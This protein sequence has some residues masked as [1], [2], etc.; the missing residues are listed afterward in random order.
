MDVPVPSSG[1]LA[2]GLGLLLPP[3]PLARDLRGV[4]CV[5]VSDLPS[6]P[7]ASHQPPFQCLLRHL[8]VGL[9][10]ILPIPVT[11]LPMCMSV[12]TYVHVYVHVYI[13]YIYPCLPCIYFVNA[14]L[15]Y[16]IILGEAALF[17]LAPSPRFLCR[18]ECED[19]VLL[20]S[21]FLPGRY[22][23]TPFGRSLVLTFPRSSQR[24]GVTWLPPAGGPMVAC[25]S[26]RIP[27][28]PSPEFGSPGCYVN[29]SRRRIPAVL[30]GAPTSAPY[31]PPYRSSATTPWNGSVRMVSGARTTHSSST[32][33]PTPFR[34]FPVWPCRVPRPLGWLR[35]FPLR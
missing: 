33:W 29:S 34:M 15:C 35:D 13:L 14:I 23:A 2:V 19:P 5:P 12:I 31:R 1:C 10:A 22:L 9:S 11:F 21:S 32:T 26:G 6:T 8:G 27:C 16:I 28:S 7:P 17:S 18:C 20:L 4:P 25:F 30:R 24:H 3:T